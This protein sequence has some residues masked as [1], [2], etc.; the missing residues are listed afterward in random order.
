MA[1]YACKGKTLGPVTKIE[2]I[3]GLQLPTARSPKCSCLSQFP[4]FP[5]WQSLLADWRLQPS[6][7][8]WLIS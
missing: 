4:I 5:R 7:A 8:L 1:T 3:R 2:C 6:A